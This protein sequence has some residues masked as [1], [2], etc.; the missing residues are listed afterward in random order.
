[1]LAKSDL[2]L[3]NDVTARFRTLSARDPIE[4]HFVPINLSEERAAALAAHRAGDSY[5]PRFEYSTVSSDAESGVRELGSAVARGTSFWHEC[6]AQAIDNHVELI[7]VARSRDP[8]H[9]SSA[10]SNMF[11]TPTPTTIGAAI[12][13]LRDIDR[14]TGRDRTVSAREAAD[15]LNAG[16]GRVGLDGW[17]VEVTDQMAA[18]MSVSP[19]A[20]LVRVRSNCWF[21]PEDVG[22]LLVHELGTHVARSVNG[23]AQPVHLLAIGL[24]GYVATEEGFAVLNEERWFGRDPDTMRKYALRV[25]AVSASLEHGFADTFEVVVGHTTPD[26]AFE[27]VQRVKRGMIDTS[28]AGAYTKDHVY[29]SWYIAVRD[30]IERSPDDLELLLAGKFGLHHLPEVR[31]LAEEGLLVPP[32]LRPQQFLTP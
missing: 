7:E 27:I 3:L 26:D 11:G 17:T 12:D 18:K 31:R 2:S 1:M 4:R 8:S 6:L 25:L 30:H 9:L 15:R 16:L 10:T 29:L 28:V 19:T 20:N 23:A 24:P 5:E 13:L 22:R 21:S 14:V 32:S